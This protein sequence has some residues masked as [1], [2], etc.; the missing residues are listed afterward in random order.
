[1]IVSR[2]VQTTIITILSGLSYYI[3]GAHSIDDAIW[4]GTN[5][6]DLSVDTANNKKVMVGSHIMEEHTCTFLRFDQH[7]LLNATSHKPRKFD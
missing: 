3:L 4:G 2:I 6:Y 5:P 1:M 7:D